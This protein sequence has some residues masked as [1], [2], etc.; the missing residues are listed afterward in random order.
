MPAAKVKDPTTG[1]YV[2]ISIASV[3]TEIAGGHSFEITVNFT[4]APGTGEPNALVSL[5]CDPEG[6]PVVLPA[7]K[8]VSAQSVTFVIQTVDTAETDVSIYAHANGYSVGDFTILV[9]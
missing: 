6:A 7:A 4:T 5:T 1:K 3:V 8:P 9:T 2:P